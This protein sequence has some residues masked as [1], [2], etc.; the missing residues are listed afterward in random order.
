MPFHCARNMQNGTV[1]FLNPNLRTNRTCHVA[2][3]LE[4]YENIDMAV[5]QLHE[6]QEDVGIRFNE[7]VLDGEQLF[8]LHYPDSSTGENLQVSG[9]TCKLST[10]DGYSLVTA[11]DSSP[12]SSGGVYINV[13][14]EIVGMH[15]GAHGQFEAMSG[16]EK[17]AFRFN[18]VI[19][20]I[21]ADS[22]IYDFLDLEGPKKIKQKDTLVPVVTRVIH[23]REGSVDRKNKQCVS[24]W[25]NMGK[26][27]GEEIRK[28]LGKNQKGIRI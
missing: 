13:N 5:V 27:S 12:G 15:I 22:K 3:I 24:L 4:V 14:G 11:H 17:Y 26:A 2:S 23:K 9:N 8:L 19:F 1:Q 21:D 25:I 16:A 18:G 28:K 10:W 6:K 7:T 20:S